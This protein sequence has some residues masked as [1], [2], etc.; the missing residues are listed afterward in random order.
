[1]EYVSAP[2]TF[3]DTPLTQTAQEH[4]P[5]IVKCQVKGDPKPKVLWKFDGRDLTCKYLI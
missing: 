5:T 3:I 4:H 1:M 2:I